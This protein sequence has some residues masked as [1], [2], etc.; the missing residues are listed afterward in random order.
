MAEVKRPAEPASFLEE[1]G[2][3]PDM[4][5][6]LTI[7]TFIGCGISAILGTWG[8]LHA[9]ASYDQLAASNLNDNP[10]YGIMQR[11][12]GG[13]PVETTRI[14]YE[15]RLP[16]FLLGLI[17]WALCTYGALQMRKLK[18]PGY[19][20]YLIGEVLPILSTFLFFEKFAG[21]IFYIFSYCLLGLFIILYSTQVKYL[22]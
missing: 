12:Y 21:G 4:L 11:L 14:S 8:L 19:Y 16:L 2:K 10:A 9:K 15:N 5:N 18:K 20:I 13:D 7:L 6:V 1:P 3:I 17:G 22:R